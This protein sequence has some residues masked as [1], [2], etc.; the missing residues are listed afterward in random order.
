MLAGKHKYQTLLSAPA[1]PL[2][3]RGGCDL[4]QAKIHL[5]FKEILV[6]QIEVSVS[7]LDCPRDG[8]LCLEDIVTVQSII[9]CLSPE[10]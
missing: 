5:S 8:E 9:L 6:L 7:H 1:Y 4:I 10:A 2:P 3:S